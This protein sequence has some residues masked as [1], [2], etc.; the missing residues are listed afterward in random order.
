[1][2][3]DVFGIQSC[4][5]CC[6]ARKWLAGQ[7]LDFRWIDLRESAPSRDDVERWL[8]AVGA[9]VLVNRRSTTWRELGEAERPELDSPAVID[10]LLEHPTLIKR[11]LFERG[12]ELRA[13]FD[14]ARRQWL[15][16]K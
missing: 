3:V 1:M 5:T 10:L 8:G 7:Q 16:Q 11:P 2:R 9:E 14:D 13:G 15:L 12:D 6:K 4:D